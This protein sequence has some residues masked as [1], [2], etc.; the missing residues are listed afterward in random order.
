MIHL[1]STQSPTSGIEAVAGAPRSVLRWLDAR[2]LLFG[3]LATMGSLLSIALGND[4]SMGAS[5]R[6]VAGA[7]VVTT[8]VGAL[9][10]AVADRV[11]ASLATRAALP[12]GCRVAGRYARSLWFASLLATGVVLRA[13]FTDRVERWTLVVAAAGF[14]LVAALGIIT[15]DARRRA[16]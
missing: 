13:V 4:L 9:A 10:A 8:A 1:R 14:V 3:V 12:A 6:A 7:F 15:A 2:A 5:V 11:A 16:A